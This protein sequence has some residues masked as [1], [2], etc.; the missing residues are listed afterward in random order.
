VIAPE[1][2]Y[3]TIVAVMRSRPGIRVAVARK[4]GFGPTALCIN[5]KIFAMLSSKGQLVVKLPKSRVAELILA[6]RGAHYERSH[7]QPMHEWF[8]A[9]VGMEEGW[10]S[11][12]EEALS[13]VGAEVAPAP[14]EP[15]SPLSSSSW[16]S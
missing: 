8:V 5:D 6:G 4:R 10:L 2:R 12:A 14:G 3:A 1:Q 11:L 7:G 16:A 15:P 13:F 9:G